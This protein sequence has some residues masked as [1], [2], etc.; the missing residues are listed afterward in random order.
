[1]SE[2]AIAWRGL[3][4]DLAVILSA[5]VLGALRVLPPEAIVAV[6]SAIGGARVIA[7]N[8]GGGN[9][10][11]SAGTVVGSLVLGVAALAARRG[12]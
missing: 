5:T 6:I 2:N 9:G 1:M 8:G 7:R 4:L 3:A 12:A 10:P 11:G